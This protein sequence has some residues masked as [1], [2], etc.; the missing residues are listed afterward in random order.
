MSG[1]FEHAFIQNPLLIAPDSGD[2]VA[3]SM[4]FLASNPEAAKLLEGRDMAFQATDDD[5]WGRDEHPYRPYVVHNGIL[6]IPIQGVLLNRFSYQFG[7]W[8]TGYQYVE[9]ALARG[10]ADPQVSGIALLVHSPGGEVA[11]CF[12]LGD[13]LFDARSEKPIRAFAA[14]HA[15]SAA[16]ALA[17][18]AS[19]ISV[20]RSGGVGSIGVVTMHVDY[21]EM[22]EKSGIA[23]T[24]VFA[25]DHKVDGNAYQK[26]PDSVKDRM[27]ERIDRLYGVFT[28]T[29]ARNR[30]MEDADVRATNALTYDATSSIQEGLADRIGALDEEMVV[31]AS[32]VAEQEEENMADQNP[33]SGGQPTQTPAAGTFTQADLDAAVAAAVQEATKA[34][35]TAERE[36]AN[37]IMTSDE[38]KKRPKAAAALVKAGMAAEAAIAALADMD[39]EKATGSSEQPKGKSPFESA[40]ETGN[41]GVGANAQ[42]E[43]DQGEDDAVAGFFAS[44]GMKPPAGHPQQ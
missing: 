5:Y 19:E 7:R 34:G 43:P 8:A 30:G 1:P 37:A 2:L 4:R 12:E 14:D 16:Y 24:F 17:S 31:F 11:G 38:G 32:E 29:V 9:R 21:S 28:G 40:M 41:P 6:Q 26:L 20:T 22:L 36:R 33:K 15:Y 39:E 13:K 23:V 10:L 3:S 25:G 18:A 27:Q 44:L 35:A 42:S